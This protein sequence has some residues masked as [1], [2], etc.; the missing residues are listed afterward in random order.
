MED[1]M[2]KETGSPAQLLS[3]PDSIFSRLAATQG[4]EAAEIM[5]TLSTS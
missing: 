4:L 3:R 5:Q 2:L 1:G